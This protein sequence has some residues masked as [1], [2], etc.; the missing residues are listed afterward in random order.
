MTTA[1][2]S[3]I[4]KESTESKDSLC[5]SNKICDLNK[6]T[7]E[8]F[9][10]KFHDDKEMIRDFCSNFIYKTPKTTITLPYYHA[11]KNTDCIIFLNNFHFLKNGFLDKNNMKKIKNNVVYIY[12]N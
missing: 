5:L 10:H 1:T 12:Q 9:I 2:Q 6:E 8:N 3:K 4:N 7:F 11:L